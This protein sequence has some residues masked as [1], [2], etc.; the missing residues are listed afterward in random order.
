MRFPD[1]AY[2]SGTHRFSDEV[3]NPIPHEDHARSAT[4][5]AFE[6]IAAEGDINVF[7]QGL[8][9]AEGAARDRLIRVARRRRDELVEPLVRLLGDAVANSDREM[10]LEVVRV[11]GMLRHAEG[12]EVLMQ[13]LRSAATKD[14][15]KVLVEVVRALKKI[16][17]DATDALAD[18][19][20]DE[21]AIVRAVAA[22]ILGR[23][24]DER[25]V[26][27]LER[28]RNDDDEGVRDM[29]GAALERIESR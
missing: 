18:A 11:L 20:G 17:S 4:E 26:P 21:S 16:G 8:Q 27:A 24:G 13:T 5:T 9:H 15:R 6:R 25:A 1:N 29:V 19:L 22:D 23:I 28:C 10:V 12:I 14:D 2:F 7:L 3:L